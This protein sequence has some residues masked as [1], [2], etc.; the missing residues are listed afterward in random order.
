MIREE[1]CFSDARHPRLMGDW[2]NRSRPGTRNCRPWL[3]PRLCFLSVAVVLTLGS[4]PAT[5][6][7]IEH[8]FFHELRQ[9]RMFALAESE[10]RL[11][12]ARAELDRNARIDYA[13]E[14]ARTLSQHAQYT[15]GDEQRE[16]S[17][18][19][20][21][22][23]QQLLDSPESRLRRPEVVA[24]LALVQARDVSHQRW[25]TELAPQDVELKTAIIQQLTASIQEL[26]S[27]E[28]AL[29]ALGQAQKKRTIIE[30]ESAPRTLYEL[31]QQVRL[32]R[33]E[34]LLDAAQLN[35]AGSAERIAALIDAENLLRKLGTVQEDTAVTRRAQLLLLRCY[36][37]NGR[38]EDLDARLARLEAE[39]S[40]QEDRFAVIA[41]RARLMID[42]GRFLDAAQLLIEARKSTQRLS[43]ELYFLKLQALIQAWN[44]T[45]KAGDDELA[46]KLF[47]QVESNAEQA[48]REAGGFWALRCRQ[49]ARLARE[50]AEFGSTLAQLIRKANLH[51]QSGQY[52]DCVQTYTEA[53]REAQSTSQLET[54]ASLTMTLASVQLDRGH[55]AAASQLFRARFD[56]SPRS[57][58]GQRAHLLWAYTLGRE[59]DRVRTRE[60]R[61]NY[62][63]ALTDHRTLYAGSDSA[64]EAAWMLARLEERRLQYTVALD[65]YL[66]VPADH[67]RAA[68]SQLR[69]ARCYE[70]ILDRLQELNRDDSEWREQA[71]TTLSQSVARFP[72]AP[73]RLDGSQ[74]EIAIR[75]ARICLGRDADYETADGLLARVL[76]SLP[77]GELSEY[78]AWQQQVATQL[79]ILSLAGQNRIR[80]AEA[81]MQQLASQGPDDILRVLTGLAR[82]ARQEPQAIRQTIGELQLQAVA[83]LEKHRDELSPES[84]SFLKSTLAE[85]L[86]A[87]RQPRKALEV[88]RRLLLETPR[89]R[90]L[91]RTTAELETQLGGS[92]NLQ[93][94]LAHWRSLEALE[95]EGSEEWIRSRFHV[96]ATL[97]QLGKDSESRKLIDVTRL[98]YPQLGGPEWSQRFAEL[99]RTDTVPR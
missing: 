90:T 22:L 50:S 86:V 43:G 60:A 47:S 71:R 3:L 53:I 93:Q 80:D 39:W 58:D 69:A 76:Q 81:L 91:I 41:E 96:A 9:R 95:Q 75:L 15:L 1:T 28:Q 74:R 73:Q 70:R 19:A 57:A 88:Y 55:D 64:A 12:L 92:E 30:D 25:E 40:R 49:L 54:A 7:S 78:D 51:Y 56:M 87:T 34:L 20:K 31:E 26:N 45:R 17:S 8:D 6:G 94:A 82:V 97:K 63:V 21:S 23:L 61:M 99:Q 27:A 4:L 62:S 59:Y 2:R 44:E 77:A 29:H 37:Q 10:C 68:D 83:V 67:R 52:E 16:L 79:R 85:A 42:S 72:A 89:D 65:L 36:R 24:E 46:Q 38:T 14:L 33:A 18:Q 13:L 32:K 35:P 84:Q 5:A 48:S 98:L 11:Q 66:S